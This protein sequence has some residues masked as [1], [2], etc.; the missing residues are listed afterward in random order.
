MVFCVKRRID[1]RVLQSYNK[2]MTNENVINKDLKQ[3]SEI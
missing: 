1:R 2:A 3:L